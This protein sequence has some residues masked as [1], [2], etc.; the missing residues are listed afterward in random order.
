[1]QIHDKFC[2]IFCLWSKGCIEVH[3]LGNGNPFIMIHFI[4]KI[5]LSPLNCLYTFANNELSHI[6]VDLSIFCSTNL[7]VYFYMNTCRYN[8]PWDQVVLSHPILFF[9]FKVVL[10]TIVPSYFH[11]NF[12]ISLLFTKNKSRISNDLTWIYRSNWWQLKS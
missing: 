5:I 4:E 3:F 6:Y 12:R 10:A 11:I 7:L 1:M 9:L 2:V 8:K